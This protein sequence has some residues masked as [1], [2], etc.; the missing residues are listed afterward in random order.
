MMHSGNSERSILILGAAEADVSLIVAAHRLNLRVL[1]SSI[2][3]SY[4]GLV[5]SSKEY[6]VNVKDKDKLLEIAKRESVS[7]VATTHALS[8]PSAAYVADKL[9]L[10]GVGYKC[11]EMAANKG[12]MKRI[13]EKIGV[14]TPK[15]IICRTHED[16]INAVNVLGL[17]AIIKPVDSGGSKGV[18]LVRQEHELQDAFHM[19]LDVSPSTTILIEEYIEGEQVLAVGVVCAGVLK[20]CFVGDRHYFLQTGKF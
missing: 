7:A 13:Y 5:A 6:H 9:N 17:P 16:A 4:P 14:P 19:A 15:A 18:S 11:A 3:G 1:V 10:P 2:F 20:N 12:Q 8:L